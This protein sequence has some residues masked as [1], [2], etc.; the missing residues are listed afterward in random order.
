MNEEQEVRIKNN[1]SY[2]I[3]MALYIALFVA[4]LIFIANQTTGYINKTKLL[5]NPCSVCY[6]DHPILKPCIEQ[7][8]YGQ[9]VS[10][11]PNLSQQA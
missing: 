7:V 6:E 10:P 1:L 11:Y 8:M 5:R 4:L 2:W 9:G 3:T